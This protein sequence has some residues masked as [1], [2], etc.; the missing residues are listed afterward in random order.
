MKRHNLHT[1]LSSKHWELLKKHQDRYETQQKV[2]EAAL[3][4]LDGNPKQLVPHSP[5]EE[6]WTR[7]GRELT[8]NICLVQKDALKKLFES[9]DIEQMKEYIATETPG[10]FVIEYYYRKPLKECSLKEI[11]EGMVICGKVSGWFDTIN[12]TDDGDHYTLKATHSL[13]IN[14]SKQFVMMEESV[15]KNYGVKTDKHLSERSFFLKIFKNGNDG[16]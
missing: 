16:N 3:E 4:S 12:Y 8:K 14:M 6:F 15:Y 7:I 10:E 11:V 13:G 9:A 2:L 5:E 1:T